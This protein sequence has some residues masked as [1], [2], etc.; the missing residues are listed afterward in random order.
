MSK[1]V[2]PNSGVTE[3]TPI[4]KI[5]VKQPW[6]K[7]EPSSK[8]GNCTRIHQTNFSRSSLSPRIS[9]NQSTVA[10][11]LNDFV[12]GLSFQVVV[13]NLFFVTSCYNT[14][15]HKNSLSPSPSLKIVGSTEK[16]IENLSKQLKRMLS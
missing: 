15:I 4:R 12:V 3:Y 14:N 13:N 6:K 16:P 8:D 10:N 11:I 1:R 5:G 9:K 7:P 2:I